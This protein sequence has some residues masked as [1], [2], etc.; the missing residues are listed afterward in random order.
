MLTLANFVDNYFDMNIF[1]DNVNITLLQRRAKLLNA[2]LV[3]H[4]DVNQG[5][6]S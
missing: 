6:Y 5:Y 2:M 4:P 1:I 3:Y